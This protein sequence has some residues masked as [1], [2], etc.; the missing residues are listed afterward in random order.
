[1]ILKVS[2]QFDCMTVDVMIEK[3]AIINIF[4]LSVEWFNKSFSGNITS[5]T[6][7]YVRIVQPHPL[8]TIVDDGAWNYIERWDLWAKIISKMFHPH[9]S[10][11][12]LINRSQNVVDGFLLTVSVSWYHQCLLKT[13]QTILWVLFKRNKMACR[14]CS[15]TLW[16]DSARPSSPTGRRPQ[17]L[18][19]R[20]SSRL[21]REPG[22]TPCRAES[23]PPPPCP[24]WCPPLNTVSL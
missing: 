12:L 11:V 9:H 17:S 10:N 21:P 16:A 3:C 23:G 8:L 14:R 24:R 22:W 19:T 1:M 15:L 13:I 4:P 18:R 5:I 20:A 6:I 2:R 7:H